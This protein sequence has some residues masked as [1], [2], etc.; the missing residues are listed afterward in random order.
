MSG[1]GVVIG[2]VF[3]FSLLIVRFFLLVV[4]RARILG[5]AHI[6]D[7][8]MFGLYLFFRGFRLV[9]IVFGLVS[10]VCRLVYLAVSVI[11]YDWLII[12]SLFCPEAH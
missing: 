4:V 11:G 2:R 8:F 12:F 9:R 10:L 3:R 1:F 6:D 7:C 5:V